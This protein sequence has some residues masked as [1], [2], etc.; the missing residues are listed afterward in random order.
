MASPYTPRKASDLQDEEAVLQN[1]WR[2]VDEAVDEYRYA[3]PDPWAVTS[4]AVA[5]PKPLPTPIAKLFTLYAVKALG[6][7]SALVSPDGTTLT[8]E[9][10]ARRAPAVQQPP[11][12]RQEEQPE[13]DQQHGLPEQHEDDEQPAKAPTCTYQSCKDAA[14]HGT[15][16][17]GAAFC[18]KHRCKECPAGSP[19]QKKIG[20]RAICMSCL[21]RQRDKKRQR[22]AEEESNSSTPLDAD[23]V[24]QDEIHAA[25]KARKE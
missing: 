6:Y 19:P 14:E 22:N 3:Q 16:G 21:Q 4:A 8:L 20:G 9:W 12:P 17:D 2:R 10:E 11:E 1:L 13:R 18:D 5:L 7:K 24:D 25:K 15:Q 23:V